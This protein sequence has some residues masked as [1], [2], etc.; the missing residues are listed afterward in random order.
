MSNEAP[1]VVDRVFQAPIDRVWA[2]ITNPDQM[3]R[4][5]FEQIRDFRPEKGFETKFIVQNGD[6]EY[7]HHWR[8]TEV[9]P[10]QRIVYD[11]L[12]PGIP[13][14][15][16]VTWALCQTEVGARLKLTHEGGASFPKDD[17]AFSRESGV[18]GWEYFFDRLGAFVEKEQRV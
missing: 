11:W 6:K 12:Y 1:I 8:V 14:A 2:A 10:R 5:F 7:P 15:S 4:W 9:V 16:F 13:G 17:P 3:S 18:A